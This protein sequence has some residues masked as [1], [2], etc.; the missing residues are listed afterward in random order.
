MTHDENFDSASSADFAPTDDSE[1][2]HTESNTDD[3]DA[4]SHM[5]TSHPLS[6]DDVIHTDTAAP[7]FVGMGDDGFQSFIDSTNDL[8]ADTYHLV[9]DA[10]QH[11]NEELESMGLQPMSGDSIEDTARETA[12]ILELSD[13]AAHGDQQAVQYLDRWEHGVNREIA[14]TQA[15]AIRIDAQT[16]KMEIDEAIEAGHDWLHHKEMESQELTDAE[17]SRLDDKD[18]SDKIHSAD[19][20]RKAAD[21]AATRRDQLWDD[22]LNDH[23]RSPRQ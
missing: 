13:R 19:E 5:E 12:N 10:R 16:Q 15:E 1:L 7:S 8:I 18:F 23:N 4:L 20:H 22:A 11:H 2:P 21:E 14:Q 17:R 6:N 3:S 9:A